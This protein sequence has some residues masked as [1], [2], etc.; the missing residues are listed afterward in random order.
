MKKVFFVV[1]LI[2]ILLILIWYWGD[3]TVNDNKKNLDNK[4]EQNSVEK[5]FDKKQ[6]CFD[7]GQKYFNKLNKNE[8]DNASNS[9]NYLNPEYSYN[10]ELNTCLV[11]IKGF[12]DT[13]DGVWHEAYIVDLLTNEYL[14]ICNQIQSNGETKIISKPLSD[15]LSKKIELFIN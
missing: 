11:Y 6:E 1:L 3:K 9:F 5:I 2:I 7:I 8:P 12:M 15:C 14:I 4:I 13:E 10:K